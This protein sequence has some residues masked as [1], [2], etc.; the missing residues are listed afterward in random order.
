MEIKRTEY[1]SPV[2]SLPNGNTTIIGEVRQEMAKNEN[3]PN[4]IQKMDAE[5]TPTNIFAFEIA[6]SIQKAITENPSLN[7]YECQFN[8]DICPGEFNSDK[9]LDVFLRKMR[10]ESAAILYH[11]S[12]TQ[13]GS[14]IYLF[15]VSICF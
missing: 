10:N 13:I 15:K 12:I 5:P 6:K 9:C 7:S 4:F 3:N 2:I 8:T 11:Y 1:I 14:S